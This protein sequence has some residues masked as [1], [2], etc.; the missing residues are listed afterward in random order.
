MTEITVGKLLD[1]SAVRDAIHFALAPVIADTNLRP[2][3]RI[4]LVD[5]TTNRACA[6]LETVESV[7][8]RGIVDP[9]LTAPVPKEG[10][11][12][13][14]LLPNT[15]TGMRHQWE[16]PAFGPEKPSD[17]QSF[18]EMWLRNYA[19]KHN[20]YDEPEAA[21]V[22]L[23]DGLKSGELYFRGSDLHGIGDLDEPEDLA[24]HAHAV[25]GFRPDW[26]RFE[27]SCSC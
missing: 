4:G 3:Q 19:A 21:Y 25:L 16:H 20:C 12:W 26:S 9:F 22:R 15:V 27:F 6:A 1:E 14:F 24:E 2:G 17:K 18:S 10:R 8:C 23:V 5:G 11:F 13:M 7:K